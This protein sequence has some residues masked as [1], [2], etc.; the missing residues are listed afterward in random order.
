MEQW[1]EAEQRHKVEVEQIERILAR[2]ICDLST[3]YARRLIER[4]QLL[5]REIANCERLREARQAS[6]AGA[7]PKQLEPDQG[8]TK[9]APKGFDGLGQ[10]KTGLEVAKD[11]TGIMQA[12]FV[13][14]PKSW[15]EIEIVFLSDHRVEISIGDERKTYNFGELGFEDRRNGKPSFAWVM[16]RDLAERSG[17]LQRPA[18]GR[19]RASHQKRIEEIR[20][21]LRTRFKIDT[22]P[23]PFNGSVYQTSFTIGCRRCSNT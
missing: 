17:T 10:K 7:V 20:R 11:S 12:D 14:R 19:T 6:A 23:I 3:P 1:E 2:P 8:S 22:D 13:T 9:D 4:K 15:Q 21:K 5:E 18:P 16:L